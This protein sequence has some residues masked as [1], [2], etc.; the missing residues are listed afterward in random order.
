MKKIFIPFLLFS[1]SLFAQYAPAVGQPGTTAMSK[2]SSA[3]VAWAT[4][5]SIQRGFQDISDPSLGYADVGDSTAVAGIAGTTIV[6]LGDGGTAIVR[7]LHPIINGPSWDFAVFENSFSDTFLELAF[8]EVSSDGTNFFRFPASSLTDTSEQNAGFGA[9]DAAQ[10]N[11]LAGKYRA[12]YGTPF[13]LEELAGIAGL[14]VNDV[15]YV[16]IV[17][18]VGSILPQYASYDTAGRAINDPWPTAFGSGGFDLDGVGVIHQNPLAGITELSAD[19]NLS[20]YPNP[21]AAAGLLT[22]GLRDQ[23]SVRAVRIYSL[24]GALVLES[25][26]STIGASA[27]SK[28]AYL[29]EAITDKNSYRQK[30]IIQ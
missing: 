21:C 20:M 29:L 14:D 27:L 4:G 12:L 16:K 28:G 13:D 1:P 6:S 19:H 2:D 15:R 8:V 7:F 24:Q 3:F 17:D 10:L 25:A 22:V 23:Q 11:N 5:S 9:T 26:S 18:V 30:L